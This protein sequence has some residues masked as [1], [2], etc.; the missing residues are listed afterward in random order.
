MAE[1]ADKEGDRKTKASAMSLAQK[2]ALDILY[3]IRDNQWLV[4]EA[5]RVEEEE[6]KKKEQVLKRS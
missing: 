3:V 1:Q 6:K 2:A 5:Y 4:D